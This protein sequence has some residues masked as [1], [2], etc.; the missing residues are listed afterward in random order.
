MRRGADRDVRRAPELGL[1]EVRLGAA[2]EEGKVVDVSTSV[3]NVGSRRRGAVPDGHDLVAAVSERTAGRLDDDAIRRRLLLVAWS[4]IAPS[5]DRDAAALIRL[6]GADRALHA[7][8]SEQPLT[9]VAALVRATAHVDPHTAAELL[10]GLPAAL[11]RWQPRRSPQRVHD[12]LRA[13][14][15]FGAHLLVAGDVDWPVAL[16]D[17]DDHAPFTIWVRGDPSVVARTERS[18]S[19]VGARAATPAGIATA[20]DLAAGAAE[21]GFV[22]VSGGAF[23]IDGAAHLGALG[24][25]RP[26]VAV[27]AGGVDRLYPAGHQDLLRRII[28]T[29]AVV[30][31]VPCGEAPTRWRFLARN[32]IIAALG[33]ATVV[34]EA[35]ERSGAANTAGHAGSLGR[36]LGAV[37]GPVSSASSK[38]CHTLIRDADAV[39]VRNEVDLIELASPG[40]APMPLELPT[41]SERALD[42]TPS[43]T[44]S[45]SRGTERAVP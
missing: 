35:G 14:R 26:T 17:L 30:S 40:M 18:V 34:V 24:V 37:P 9:A 44:G 25:R 5:G 28:D 22:V 29:G 15:A 38:G 13:A 43:A 20:N 23:G 27:M 3:E 36:P 16:D 2:S 41:P 7:V 4:T 1:D 33:S 10:A 8:R 45:R 31:E 12:A 6:S 19:I 21:A 39:L 11:G 42:G 32:R